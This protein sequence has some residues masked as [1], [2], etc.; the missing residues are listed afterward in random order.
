MADKIEDLLQTY[1]RTETR[2]LVEVTEGNIM[3]LARRLGWKIEFKDDS[4]ALVNEHGRLFKVGSLLDS[5]GF[6]V[7]GYGW[8]LAETTDNL[9]NGEDLR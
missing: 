1:T 7:S 5:S 4:P 9:I 2:E 3:E 8:R 6:A